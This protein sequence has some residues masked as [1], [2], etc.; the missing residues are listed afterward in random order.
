MFMSGKDAKERVAEVG[1]MVRHV[2]A[3]QQAYE[4][5]P[6]DQLLLP[7]TSEKLQNLGTISKACQRS[8]HL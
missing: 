6:I 3:N 7:D 2:V 5:V 8:E 4:A 1:S